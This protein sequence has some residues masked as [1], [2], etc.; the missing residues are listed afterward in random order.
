MNVRELMN[1]QVVSCSPQDTLER[2]A[3]LMWDGDLGAV[4]VVDDDGHPVGMVTDRD[5]CIA[6][7]TQGCR[8]SESRVASAMARDLRTCKPSDSVGYA[9][10]L[11]RKYQVRRLPVVDGGKLVGMVSLNDF[12]TAAA[13]KRGNKASLDA[14]GVTLARISEP[15]RLHAVAAQ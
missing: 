5:I 8:L 1:S 9:E 13:D 4:P 7:Y 3:Q 2:A 10:E 15:R 11:M 14:L 12:A 6:A